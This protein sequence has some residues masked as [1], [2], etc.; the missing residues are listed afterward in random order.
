MVSSIMAVPMVS[1]VKREQERFYGHNH[2]EAAS[3]RTFSEVLREAT[4][5]QT[6]KAPTECY[7]TTYGRN[8]QLQHFMYL[9]REYHY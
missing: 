6:D 1:K 5:Q 9:T 7:I 8:R 4:E 3:E 2:E